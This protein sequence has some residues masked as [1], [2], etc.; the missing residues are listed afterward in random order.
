MNADMEW[1]H[2]LLHGDKSTVVQF[3]KKPISKRIKRIFKITTSKFDVN[4]KRN[5]NILLDANEGMKGKKI[6]CKYSLS[7][8][9]TRIIIRRHLYIALKKSYWTYE[10]WQEY[11]NETKLKNL[12][13]S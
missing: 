5:Y 6:A 2:E 13:N 9:S 11:T 12:L 8:R 10:E 7:A 1:M 4:S 3:H